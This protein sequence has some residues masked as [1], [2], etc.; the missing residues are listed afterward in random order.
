[1]P[2]TDNP[3]I[4]LIDAAVGYESVNNSSVLDRSAEVSQSNELVRVGKKS[5]FP[6]HPRVSEVMVTCASKAKIWNP[7]TSTCPRACRR[8]ETATSPRKP[9]I[10]PSSSI[11]YE[12]RV[13]EHTAS[14]QR[15]VR[16]RCKN[17][18]NK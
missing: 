14:K 5:P 11:G 6:D 4:G 13:Y 8:T 12:G 10:P 9:S 18:K 3:A 1:M 7:Y 2:F 15:K 17:G 16:R